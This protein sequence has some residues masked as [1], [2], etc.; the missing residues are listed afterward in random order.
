MMIA[1]KFLRAQIA[2]VRKWLGGTNG[3]GTLPSAGLFGSSDTGRR[4]HFG[5]AERLAER[6]TNAPASFSV[7]TLR[8]IDNGLRQPIVGSSSPTSRLSSSKLLTELHAGHV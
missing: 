2:R 8:Q 5:L 3:S 4:L 6:V 7:G 1:S